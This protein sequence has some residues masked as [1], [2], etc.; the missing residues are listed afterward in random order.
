MAAFRNNGKGGFELTINDGTLTIPHDD[1][2]SLSQA[3]TGR[4][5]NATEPR[6][7]VPAIPEP[8]PVVLIGTLIVFTVGQIRRKA[9]E[10]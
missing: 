4:I 6:V 3:L 1:T 2:S 9:R 8:L 5:T 10:S 7:A